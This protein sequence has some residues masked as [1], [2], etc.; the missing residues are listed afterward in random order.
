MLSIIRYLMAATRSYQFL[1]L[2]LLHLA[3]CAGQARRYDSPKRCDACDGWN[4]PQKPFRIFG[5][6][7]YVGVSG[8]SALMID[9]GAGLV[10]LDGGLP[11]SAPRIARNLRALGHR[12][13]EVRWIGCSHAHYDHVGGVAALQRLSGARVVFSPAG[14]AGL[15]A[16]NVLADD[17]QAGFGVEAM[18]FPAVAQ[19]VELGDGETFT[20][21]SVTV[22]AHHTPGHTPGGTS[23]SWRSCEG[24]RCINMV[25]ADS[26]NPVS[27]PGFRYSAD[28]AQLAAFRASIDKV[29]QLPCDVIISAHPGFTELFDR[30][31]AARKDPV[32]ADEAFIDPAG[33]ATYADDAARRLDKRLAEEAN[34][35]K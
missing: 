11:Q 31:A 33:C 22:M 1:L 8:L 5:N 7:Y 35:H 20:L 14:A 10:L 32:K 30:L 3:A 15:R 16:G 2:S 24:K 34:S 18:R 21:G 25:Y 29:R 23:W 17:P 26:L 12:I 27:A 9:T 13:D 28:S 4:G 19:V 6:T